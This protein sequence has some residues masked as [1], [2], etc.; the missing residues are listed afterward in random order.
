[1]K[2]IDADSC[3]F[4]GIYDGYEVYLALF[5]DDGLVAAKSLKVIDSIIGA[6][7]LS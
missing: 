3:I 6:K 5:V 4:Y 7:L 1:M 2:E